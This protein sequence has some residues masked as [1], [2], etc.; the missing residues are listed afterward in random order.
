MRSSAAAEKSCEG[1]ALKI[2]IRAE[3]I[4]ADLLFND[5]API[6]KTRTKKS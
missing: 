4:T 5:L 2:R 1:M 6:I 3:G